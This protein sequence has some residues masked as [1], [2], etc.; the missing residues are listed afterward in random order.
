MPT[1]CDSWIKRILAVGILCLISAGIPLHAQQ[2]QPYTSVHAAGEH[3]VDLKP[4]K[5]RVTIT[6]HAEGTDAKTAVRNLAEHKARVKQDL[7]TLKA[8]EDSIKFGSTQV[9]GVIGGMMPPVAE[10]LYSPVPPTTFGPPVTGNDTKLFRAVATV[11][12]DWPLP[13]TDLDA[14]ALLPDAIRAQ[15]EAHDLRGEKNKAE[16]SPEEQERREEMQL[17]IPVQY[18]DYEANQQIAVSFVA[19]IEPATRQDALKAAFE[20]AGAEAEMLAAAA[21]RKRGELVRLHCT[22]SFAAPILNY[23]PAPM[24]YPAP[25]FFQPYSGPMPQVENEV[26]AST[27]DG[28]KYSVQVTTEFGLLK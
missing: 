10:P 18:S 24:A 1:T 2:F 25:A 5:L 13:T 20:K 21:S 8:E 6:M 11:T 3:S 4:Q 12:A 9:G 15:V 27:P 28:L 23:S 17:H 19:P 14:L 16:L 7:V 26:T 22:E